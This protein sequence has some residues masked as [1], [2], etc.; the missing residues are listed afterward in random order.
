MQS[1]LQDV[2]FPCLFRTSCPRRKQLRARLGG[3]RGAVPE[4]NVRRRREGG[5]ELFEFFV[6]E[7][8]HHD[9]S[10]DE[11]AEADGDPNEGPIPVVL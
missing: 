8:E 10:K 1:N 5:L 6:P 9:E 2:V 11:D 4:L 3:L 7:E